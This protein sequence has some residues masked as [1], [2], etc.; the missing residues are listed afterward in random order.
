MSDLVTRLLDPSFKHSGT[1]PAKA[2]D[3]YIAARSAEQAGEGEIDPRL[4]GI[5][6]GIF[7]RCLADGEYKQVRTILRSSGASVIDLTPGDWY[8]T[9]VAPS[10][11]HLPHLRD[12][13]R[14][15]L[16]LIH[17]GRCPGY[18]IPA[19]VPRPSSPIPP[20]PL[21]TSVQREQVTSC[22]LHCPITRYPQLSRAHHP[23]SNL[24]SPEREFISLPDGIRFG[25]RGFTRLLREHQETAS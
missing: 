20:S 7:R 12:H 16:A 22:Q 21:P 24:T 18:R 15:W 23:P 14:C 1:I 19:R 4:Q 10:G 3:R 25:R 9:R 17:N 8:C 5:I 2:I 13:P 11:R 6:E